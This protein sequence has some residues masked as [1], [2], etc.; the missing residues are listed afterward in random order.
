MWKSERGSITVEAVFVFP[1]IFFVLMAIMYA[2]FLYL[3]QSKLQT[4]VDRWAVKQSWAMEQQITLGETLKSR[5]YGKHSLFTV[6]KG[7]KEQEKKL[8][9]K[10]K[11]ELEQELIMGKIQSVKTNISAT[12]IDIQVQVS[13]NIGISQVKEYFTGTPLVYTRQVQIPVH[14]SPEFARVYDVFDQATDQVKGADKV[15]KKMQDLLNSI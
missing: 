14:N 13:M 2:T 5:N 10:V 1:I 12:S 6:W 3:D 15:K 9:K 11:A 8:S 4:C 7:Q